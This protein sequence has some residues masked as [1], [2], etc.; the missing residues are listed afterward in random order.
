M[1]LSIIRHTIL[2][3]VVAFLSFLVILY[4]IF[5]PTNPSNAKFAAHMIGRAGKLILG[6]DIEVQGSEKLQ[7][8]EP[9]VVISNHQ[10]N[11]DIFAVGNFLPSKTVSVGKKSILYVPFFG[12][13]YWLTGNILIDRGNKRKA[14][15]VMDKVVN[16]IKEND[17]R[18]WIMPEGTRSKGRGVLRFKKGAFHTAIK[19]QVKVI[20]V[21]FSSIDKHLDFT[22]WKSGVIKVKVLEPISTEGLDMNNVSD[23]TARVHDLVSREV[24]ALDRSYGVN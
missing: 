20:P 21:C 19:A 8:L 1:L 2:A 23:L 4:S 12:I 15:A 3:I 6:F 18:V 24:D 13:M 16:A 9:C 14:W 5:R 10:S 22:K 11:Y 7:N 17:T